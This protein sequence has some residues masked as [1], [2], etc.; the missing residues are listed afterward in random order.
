MMEHFTNPRNIGVLENPSASAEA[1]NDSCGDVM[2]L[3]LRVE[4][5]VVAAACFKTLGCAAAIAASSA[6]TEML[7][8]GT[9][10]EARALTKERLNDALGGLPPVKHHALDLA[11]DALGAA[12][13]QVA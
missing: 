7:K 3:Y 4:D 13:R 12:L 11:L 1:R 6:L 8:H 2:K 10:R 5:G 9:L